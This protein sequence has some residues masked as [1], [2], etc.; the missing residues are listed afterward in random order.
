MPQGEICFAKQPSFYYLF[1]HVHQYCYNMEIFYGDHKIF[2]N[3]D[4]WGTTAERTV[5]KGFSFLKQDAAKFVRARWEL[6]PAVI[7][8]CV[9]ETAQRENHPLFQ[10][11]VIFSDVKY[12]VGW[13]C[14]SVCP[15][16]VSCSGK[17]IYLNTTTT[18]TLVEYA[19]VC[20]LFS[21]K[22][23]HVSVYD[24]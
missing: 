8:Q 5:V 4:E 2:N 19:L 3:Q 10:M 17:K 7:G 6:G 16:V 18:L 15:S 21:L 24:R 20:I 14:F 11:Y 12:V 13:F 9:A 22:S 23:V 1:K